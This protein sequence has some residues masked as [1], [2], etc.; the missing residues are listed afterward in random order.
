MSHS[1][2]LL[3]KSVDDILC[4]KCNVRFGFG[5]LCGVCYEAI[6]LFIPSGNKIIDDFISYTLTNNAEGKMMFVPYDKFENIELIGEGGFSKVYKATWIDC[7]VDSRWGTGTLNY[8]WNES[9][10]VALK[11]LNNS[12]N[13]TSKELNEVKFPYVLTY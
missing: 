5:D 11:K 1:D 4:I 6:E 8:F 2:F 10:T 9:K 3:K 12:N 13:I 7:K